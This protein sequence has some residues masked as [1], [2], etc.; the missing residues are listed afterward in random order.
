MDNK[1][2]ALVV[3]TRQFWPTTTGHETVMYYNCKGLHEKYGYEVYLYCFA[4]KNTNMTIKK[5]DFIKEVLF[6]NIPSKVQSLLTLIFNTSARSQWPLQNSLYYSK[7][8]ERKLC[9]YFEK[10]CPSVLFIDMVRLVPYIYPF[11][12]KNINKILFAEDNL[13]KRYQRQL[14]VVNSGN[15]I[16]YFS[17]NMSNLFNKI[18]SNK[19]IK[20]NILSTEITRLEKYEDSFLDLF[21]YIT[22]ISPIETNEFNI[23]HNTKKAITLTMGADVEF[24]SEVIDVKEVSNS[25]V[26]VGNLTYAPN[27]DSI[28]YI[29][30]DI[31]P[32]LNPEIVLYIIGKCPDLFRERIDGK[33]SKVLGYVDDIRTTVKSM[34]LYVSPIAYGTGIK[35]KVIEAMAMGMCVITNS[36]GAEALAVTSG[37]ELVI[38]DTIDDLVEKIN[39]YLLH[40]EERK[41]I[42]R[43][44]KNYVLANHR[45]DKVYETFKVMDL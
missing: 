16:G 34:E 17:K 26:F 8:N 22:F 28:E 5:P 1:K 23:R 21:N 30:T 13:A 7:S 2:K 29:C 37:T 3:A 36:V 15:A 39:Y 9:D 24:L 35:T 20:K 41:R 10:I 12:D 45:W 32:K 44:A 14:N 19:L 4:D 11:K 18:V 43:A 40:K 6:V 38:A 42:G 33:Q 31:L 27:A 25:L